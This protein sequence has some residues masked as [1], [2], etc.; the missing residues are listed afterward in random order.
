M[1]PILQAILP[2]G[3]SDPM[4]WDNPAIYMAMP[5]ATVETLAMTAVS[6]V[7]T[8]ILGVP[9]GLVLVGTQPGGLFPNR[10]VNQ[11]LSLIVN[12]GRSLPFVIL[13]IAL[14]PFTR[15]MAGTTLGWKAACVPLVVGA[16]P[17]FARLVETNVMGID[18]GKIEAAKMMGARR[19]QIMWGV[20]VREALP[21]LIQ[22]TT[23]LIIT[24]VGY[25]AITGMLG[26]GGLGALAMSYGYQR[27]QVDTMIV[28][29]VV[30]AI[31]VEIVQILG[32][33]LSRWVDHR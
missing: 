27:W 32:D 2:G 25:S 17:F 5:W 8:V 19:G 21:A 1:N 31:M 11:V 33:M 30:L 10:A 23:V 9:L 6:G 14:I 29:V 24:L 26:G 7:I 28:A 3:P 12:I 18:P 16:V 4:W 13:C 15:F 22:S 20:Q